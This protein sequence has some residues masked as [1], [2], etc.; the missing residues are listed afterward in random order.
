MPADLAYGAL[1]DAL[2]DDVEG[3]AKELELY[4]GREP[5]P[6]YTLQHEIDGVLR[7]ADEAGFDR[8]H[9]VG[10]SAGGASSVA[11]AASQPERLSSLALFEPAWM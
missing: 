10:Y 6:D 5:P 7:V 3:I 2:G 1:V 11:F 4:A 8:F 9:L